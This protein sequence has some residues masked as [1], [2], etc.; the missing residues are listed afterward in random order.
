MNHLRIAI[1]LFI[2]IIVTVQ[3]SGQT[4]APTP[5]AARNVIYGE[6]AS[7][8]IMGHGSVN[9]ERYLGDNFSIRVG[10]GMGYMYSNGFHGSGGGLFMLN[11]LPTT[12]HMSN[13]I[14]LEFG[15]GISYALPKRDT[16]VSALNPTP[17]ISFGFRVKG[18]DNNPFLR[19][20]LTYDF[21]YGFPLQLSLG[22]KFY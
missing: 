1:L 17:A 12:N 5:D 16:V 11:Y 18:N 21:R 9:Y 7:G 14:H 4:T 22:T 8:L 2:W 15:A 6:I 10:A 20:G 13:G 3:G 19:L